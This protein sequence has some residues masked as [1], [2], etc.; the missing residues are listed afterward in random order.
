MP[1]PCPGGNSKNAAITLILLFKTVFGNDPDL[2][3][4]KMLAT[5][6]CQGLSACAT[7]NTNM[8]KLSESGSDASAR[9]EADAKLVLLS[10]IQAQ[11]EKRGAYVKELLKVRATIESSMEEISQI[12]N[13]E[14]HLLVLQ[15]FRD[16]DL[17][18]AFVGHRC[19]DINYDAVFEDCVKLHGA[20]L[21]NKLAEAAKA[22]IAACKDWHE[23][24]LHY[25]RAQAKPEDTVASLQEKAAKSISSL[26]PRDLKKTT[27]DFIAARCSVH[28]AFKCCNSGFDVP[29]VKES[30][31]MPVYAMCEQVTGKVQ[32]RVVWHGHACTCKL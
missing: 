27:D 23:G 30:R 9:L 1:G 20:N 19:E 15:S 12:L 28:K 25:W 7:C 10:T 6:Q 31:C 17:T 24:G 2:K 21:V 32:V 13:E 3:H 16:L 11:R 29:L 26:S 5:V 22:A 18:E 8:K 4:F 14:K